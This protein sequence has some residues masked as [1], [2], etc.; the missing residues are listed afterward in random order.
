M[1]L[2]NFKVKQRK[3]TS[4]KKFQKQSNE[5]KHLK[6]NLKSNLQNIS[7]AKQQANKAFLFTSQQFSTKATAA[8]FL[9][10]FF[11]ERN[12]KHFSHLS[13]LK[14]RTTAERI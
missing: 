12:S 9:Y 7:K 2:T 8:I 13:N 3:E 10:F 14:Q 11:N 6:G 1:M 5:K 4:Q